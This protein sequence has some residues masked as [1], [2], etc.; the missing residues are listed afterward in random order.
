MHC[1]FGPEDMCSS[2]LAGNI[3]YVHTVL[4]SI[5]FF[6]RIVFELSCHIFF[7]PV[8]KSETMCTGPQNKSPVAVTTVN[9]YEELPF[10]IYFQH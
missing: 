1:G 8:D 10:G 7:L 6:W 4:P 5:F 2:F 3:T 9:V